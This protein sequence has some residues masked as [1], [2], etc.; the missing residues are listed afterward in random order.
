MSDDSRSYVCVHIL[1]SKILNEMFCGFS[2]V[3]VLSRKYN[4]SINGMSHSEHSAK[5]ELLMGL[6]WTDKLKSF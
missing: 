6:I 3:C 1:Y 2:I 5:I 4:F